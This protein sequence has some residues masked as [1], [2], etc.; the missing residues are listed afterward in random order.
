[1]LDCGQGIRKNERAVQA[2]QRASVLLHREQCH[3]M[4]GVV[5]ETDPWLRIAD[6]VGE[7]PAARNDN[8]ISRA[9]RDRR[10][11]A[12]QMCGERVAAAELYDRR[13]RAHS[14]SGL[15]VAFAAIGKQMMHLRGL[16]GTLAHDLD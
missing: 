12:R 6:R 2:R 5:A 16:D 1:M 15:W 11:P 7:R 13:G 8:D 4:R 10:D 14:A 3:V 9:T